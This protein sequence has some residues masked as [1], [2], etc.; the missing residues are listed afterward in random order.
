MEKDHRS[1]DYNTFNASF[2]G[3]DFHAYMNK[4]RKEKEI[5][6]TFTLENAA[7]AFE[8]L[9]IKKNKALIEKIIYDCL[10]TKQSQILS[11]TDNGENVPY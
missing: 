11:I 1:G 3:G 6:L 9:D 2:S 4:I 5:T 10:K 7:S 8:L